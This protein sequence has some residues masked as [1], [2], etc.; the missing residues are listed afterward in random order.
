MIH[1]KN[2]S[3]T[4]GRGTPLETKVLE[5]LT[6]TLNNHEFTT[7]IGSNGAGKSTL[8]NIISGDLKPD[9]GHIIIN[10]QDVT[11]LSH[12]QRAPL[13]SRVFQDPLQGT[14]AMLNIEENLA[15]ALYRGKKRFF[16]PA[17]NKNKRRYFQEILAELGIG[18]EKRLQ[19][20]MGSLSGGQRQA[21]SLL[22][23]TLRPCQ[24]LLL[25]EHTAALDP[26]M[27]KVILALT[28][29][30]IEKSN[31]CAIMITHSMSHALNHGTK[32]LLLH[33]G[34]ILKT[35]EGTQ[36]DTTTPQD[37]HLLFDQLEN[38]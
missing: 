36:R 18:L 38:V 19:D 34:S 5:N 1:L 7:V 25:D 29:K 17:L 15:L 21:A 33:Q 2:I 16:T 12:H 20:P 24:I 13:I 26:K 30:I 31:L 35:L 23:A 27:A 9:S 37:L 11:S 3:V 10:G 6:L 28:E 8:M 22:M 4:F 32:T 14:C